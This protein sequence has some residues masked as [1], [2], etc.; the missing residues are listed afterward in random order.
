LELLN[1]VAFEFT[2]IN[3][4]AIVAIHNTGIDTKIG[5]DLFR[6]FRNFLSTRFGNLSGRLATYRFA[7][8]F[9]LFEKETGIVLLAQNCGDLASRIF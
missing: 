1:F 5:N 2:S 6:L 4:K 8:V 3:I 9:G 7:C